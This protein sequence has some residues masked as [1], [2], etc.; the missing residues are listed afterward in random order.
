VVAVEGFRRENGRVG[1]RNHVA[2]IPVDDLSNAACRSVG[3]LVPATLPLPHAYGR[4]QYG[5]DLELHFRTMIGTGA[6]PNVA[7]AIVIGIEPNWTARIAEGIAATG[8]PVEAFS[9]EGK[10]DLETV[11]QA[12]HVAQSL[13]QHASEQRR[14]TVELGELTVSIKCGESDTTTGLA[15]CPTVGVVVDQLVE[16]GATVLF[17]ETPELTGGEHLIAARCASDALREQFMEMYLRY[18]GTIEENGADLLGS[19]PTQGNIAGGLSTIEEK[20]LGNIEKTGTA[21]V[22]GVLAPAQAPTNGTRGLYFMDSS[23]A[24]AEHITLMC[25]G[26]AVLHIFPTG[27]GN[28]VGHPVEPVIK[29]TANPATAATMVEHIDLDVSGL[30]RRE[31]TLEQAGRRLSELVVRTANGRL[32]CAE[33]LAHREFALTRLYPSA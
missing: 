28:V 3:A 32:T 10:G 24:A 19:Q 1:V 27:Q 23:S 8:K 26:G 2:V 31:L 11:R 9:I 4:L 6:N 20:A 13:V 29:L 5:E 14:E 15:S 21:Q 12:A 30:L 16:A 17:G 18:V 33:T 25:A 7:A 22:V